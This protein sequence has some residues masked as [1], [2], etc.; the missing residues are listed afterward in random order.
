[1]SAA[2]A[3]VWIGLLMASLQATAT[4]LGF[5]V[6][7][8]YLE[9]E[10]H[11]YKESEFDAMTANIALIQPISKQLSLKIGFQHI[12]AS[13]AKPESGGDLDGKQWTVD[14]LADFND[15]RFHPYVAVGAGYFE[16]SKDVSPQVSTRVGLGVTN[17]INETISIDGGYTFILNSAKGGSQESMVEIGIRYLFGAKSQ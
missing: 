7:T 10:A 5:G 4:E 6:G 9:N 15:T 16:L 3:F 11:Q 12:F 17:P 2:K 14:L 8:L 13:F 1:M